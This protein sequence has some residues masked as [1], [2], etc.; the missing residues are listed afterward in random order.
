MSGDLDDEVVVGSD[1]FIVSRVSLLGMVPRRLDSALLS[2][3]PSSSLSQGLWTVDD[4]GLFCTSVRSN[5]NVASCSIL[6]MSCSDQVMAVSSSSSH[7]ASLMTVLLV[8]SNHARVDGPN[9]LSI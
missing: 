1:S 3:V 8:G 2:S 9:V 5:K 4:P 7:W 6:S